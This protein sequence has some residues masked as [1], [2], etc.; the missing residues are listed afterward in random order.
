M[1]V[2]FVAVVYAAWLFLI[3]LVF[4]LVKG[5]GIEAQE[6]SVLAGV[7]PMGLQLVFVGFDP[8]GMTRPARFMIAMFAIILLSY[9]S[10]GTGWD[11]VTYSVLYLYLSFGTLLV[12]GSPDRRLLALIAEF[13]S[14]PTALWLLYIDQF[15]TYVWGRLVAGTLESN[16]WGLMAL[17]V[18]IAAFAHRSRLLG[19]FCIAA[20]FLTMVDAS[21]RSSMVGLAAA[22]AVIGL[23]RLAELKN[24]K[25]IG[26]LALTAA[27]LALVAAVMP[28]L[29]QAVSGFADNL[30]KLDDPRRGLGTGGTG[31]YI[32]WQAA[33]KIWWD[34]PLFGIGFR[35]HER[36]MPRHFEAHNAYIA[37]LADTGICGFLWYVSLLVAF[38]RGMFKLAD[39]RLRYLAIGLATSYALVG[40]FERRAIDGANPMSW[41]FLMSAMMV[42]RDG[43]LERLGAAAERT[44]RAWA[45]VPLAAG[46]EALP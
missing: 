34:H 24:R 13:Y 6:V 45:A 2:Y 28:A 44:R 43:A 22:C 31:R 8:V 9:L 36:Y 18:G 17:S 33:L 38:C 19:L 46:N 3:N 10:N 23:H 4:Y 35:M 41:M 29:Q 27:A 14:I 20:A 11:A 42:L 26:A 32:Y 7:L 12:A 37:M 5:R 21:S 1:Q 39:K 15:G 16:I 30:M 40:L 25:L